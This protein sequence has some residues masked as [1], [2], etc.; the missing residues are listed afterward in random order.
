[1]SHKGCKLPKTEKTLTMCLVL[2]VVHFRLNFLQSK[3]SLIFL[4]SL[5]GFDLNVFR[6]EGQKHFVRNSYLFQCLTL[7]GHPRFAKYVLQMSKSK[8]IALKIERLDC[9]TKCSA[10]KQ[11]DAANIS[12]FFVKTSLLTLDFH[13]SN[14]FQTKNNGKC[15]GKFLRLD[16]HLS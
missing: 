1:M 14:S 2:Q 11:L 10:N 12:F 6:S 5:S 3:P 4:S 13:A 15:E 9:K 16:D 7:L 8:Q